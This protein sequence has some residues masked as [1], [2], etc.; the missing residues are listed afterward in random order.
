M[1]ILNILRYIK[2]KITYIIYGDYYNN[3]NDTIQNKKIICE[4]AILTEYYNPI[5][6]NNI[7]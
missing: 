6:S 5:Y 2:N 3:E 1:I 7:E 4:D